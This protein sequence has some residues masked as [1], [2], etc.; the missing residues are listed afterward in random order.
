MVVCVHCGKETP[1]PKTF[2]SV[3]I[4]TTRCIRCDRR[5]PTGY[6]DSIRSTTEICKKRR[7]PKVTAARAMALSNAAYQVAKKNEGAQYIVQ[8]RDAIWER[9][10]QQGYNQKPAMFRYDT[11]KGRSYSGLHDGSAVAAIAVFDNAAAVPRFSIYVVFR[12]SDSSKKD[13]ETGFGVDWRA[14]SD[15]KQVWAGY[16]SNDIRVNRGFKQFLN[17]YRERVYKRLMM[18][19]ELLPQPNV[20]ITGHSQG[21]AHAQLFAHWMAYKEPNVPLFCVP[22]APPRVGNLAF[23]EDFNK[24]IAWK[25]GILPFDGKSY[26]CY[27]MVLGRDPVPFWMAHGLSQN[28]NVQKNDVIDGEDIFPKQKFIQKWGGSERGD[29]CDIYF[30]PCYLTRVESYSNWSTWCHLLDHKPDRF[31]DA[32][33]RD[34]KIE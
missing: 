21:A 20:V 5:T 15:T 31:R 27:L 19:W 2:S 7:Y 30:H 11:F 25:S 9:I 17:S 1:L 28:A 3:N 29:P 8:T 16:G 13:E 24:K 10:K 22:F 34:L 32:I 23:A 12:G 33:K 6:E 26:R 4:V 14:A 18:Y